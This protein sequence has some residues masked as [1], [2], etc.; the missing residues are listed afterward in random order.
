MCFIKKGVGKMKKIIKKIINDFFNF[1]FSTKYEKIYKKIKNMNVVSFDVF[2]TLIKRN[3]KK[4]TDIFDLIEKEY[5]ES[6]KQ[7]SNFKLNRINAEKK[8]RLES[9]F[10]DITLM[11]I[12]KNMNEYTIEQKDILMKIELNVEKDMCVKNI[13]MVPIYKKCLKDNKKIFFISDMYLPFD[14]I[15]EILNREGFNQYEKIYISSKTKL[16]KRTGNIF[17]KVLDENDLNKVKMIHIGDAPIGD[18]IMPRKYG[19]KTIL[20]KRSID[21][22]IFNSKRTQELDYNILSTFINNYEANLV[23]ENEFSKF[24]YEILGPLLYG[25]TSW[26]HSKVK[27]ENIEKLYFLARDAKIIME[28]YHMRYKNDNISAYY[29]NVSRKSV[30]IANLD[31]I[32]NFDEVYLKFKS[33]LKKTSKVEDFFYIVGLKFEEY[34][35]ILENSKIDRTKYLMDLSENEKNKI[36]TIIKEDLQ[37]NSRLQRQYLKK[38]LNQ[39]NMNGKIA[40]IDVGWNGTIQYY[41]ENILDSDSKIYGYYYGVNT[42]KKYSEHA[43]C[44]RNG[45]LF[46]LENKNNNQMIIEL[47]SGLFEIMFL[48]PEGTTVSYK[49]VNGKIE[50]VYGEIEYSKINIEIVKQI[51]NM[52]K[53][54]CVNALSSV[55][56]KYLDN[57]PANVYFENYRQ[58]STNPKN[59][60]I[61]LFKNIEFENFNKRKLIENKSIFY[62]LINPKK[63][64]IDFINSVCK[65]MFIKSVF[66]LNIPYNKILEKLFNYYKKN[67]SSKEEKC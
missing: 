64:Y 30:I 25:F 8:A 35:V 40:I 46:D 34:E 6:F 47:S 29:I 21:N 41:L 2:D 10:E 62:Y 51:Q 13:L 56:Q 11:D 58:L 65:I 18:F 63:F 23:N 48:S 39:N 66:K 1:L 45:Y 32:N 20:I 26:L 19:I 14:V 15:E 3:V 7:I 37:K 16:S 5:N 27:R 42:N 36:F 43:K 52:A 50:P 54:F 49:E 12:Y 24:G 59:K 28:I 22:S 38:Y 9:K 55:S 33:I 17:R 57:L 44:I 67:N 31:K 53:F 60:H 61:K 4:P